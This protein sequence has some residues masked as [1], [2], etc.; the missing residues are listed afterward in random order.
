MRRAQR[1]GLV[2]Q[3]AGVELQTVGRAAASRQRAARGGPGGRRH[4]QTVIAGSRPGL[5]QR[6]RH[7]GKGQALTGARDV[8]HPGLG[9][10]AQ[11][12]SAAVVNKAGPQPV[13]VDLV[14][15]RR[16]RQDL[17]VRK[18]QDFVARAVAQPQDLEKRRLPDDTAVR[19][20]Q[21]Q[22]L[23]ND[24]DAVWKPAHP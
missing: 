12:P 23:E 13:A 18:D 3:D 19:I 4:R 14:A 9:I 6:G 21:Q 24:V 1:P 11:N 17:G 10:G 16:Q 8:Q 22:I 15:P 2:E 7:P 20:G 5:G